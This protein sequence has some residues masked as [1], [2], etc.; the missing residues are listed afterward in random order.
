M[1]RWARVGHLFLRSFAEDLRVRGVQGGLRKIELTAEHEILL[2]SNG[3]QR[4]FPV[5]FAPRLNQF[6]SCI[7]GEFQGFGYGPALHHEALDIV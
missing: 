7:A 2:A 5:P 6:L 4:G 1:E 3:W